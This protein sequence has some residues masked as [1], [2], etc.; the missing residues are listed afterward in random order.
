MNLIELRHRNTQS[1][2]HENVEQAGA[3]RV[4]QQVRNDQ[5][6]TR[7]QRRCAQKKCRARQV[8]RDTGLNSP[9]ALTAPNPHFVALP[10]AFAIEGCAKCAQ[11]NFA[12]IA[13]AQRFLDAGHA[14]RK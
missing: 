2:L 10:N 4:H 1:D 8:A 7:E 3:R 14:V 12:V 5:L 11:R 9:Q 6:R 13:G